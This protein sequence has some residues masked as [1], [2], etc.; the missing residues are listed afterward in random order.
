MT[1]FTR[2]IFVFLLAIAVLFPIEHVCVNAEDYDDYVREVL[3]E[4]QDHSGQEYHHEDDFYE[5]QQQQQEDAASQR[6]AEEERLIREQA[7]RV[8]AKREQNFQAE[9]ARMNAEQ[10]KAAMRQKKK[11]SKVVRS[12]LKAA[13][14]NKHYEVLGIRN[15]D[16][17]IPSR[18]INVA[19]LKFAIPGVTLKETSTKDIR[20]GYRNRAMSV[21]PDKNRDGRAQEAF[22]AVEHSAAILADVHL[23]A[24]YDEEAK[25][26]R[27]ERRHESK[28]LA[29]NAISAA[30]QVIGKFLKAI[31]TILGPFATPVIII[32]ALL[33]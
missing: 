24:E 10:Q 4:D 22:I 13:K 11:D 32:G 12:V 8:A 28:A 17:K 33:I 1:N 14:K 2:T 21:H 25:R 23:R 30:Q 27:V 3:E 20:K 9:L 19:G 5:R 15:W 7:D 26:S 6:Q 16:M 31:H 18:T 29:F